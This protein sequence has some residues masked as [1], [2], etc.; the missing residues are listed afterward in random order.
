MHLV[1]TP[2]VFPVGELPTIRTLR[3]YP[4]VVDEWYGIR[5]EVTWERPFDSA[6][7][8]RIRNRQQRE[9]SEAHPACVLVGDWPVDYQVSKH[10]ISQVLS[11]PAYREFWQT[12][13]HVCCQEYEDGPTRE[14]VIPQFSSR[15]FQ[16][17]AWR[18]DGGDLGASRR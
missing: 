7:L 4:E 5:V 8:D 12:E 14:V 13:H 15:E 3:V 17:S 1:E 11:H 6:L 2:A 18:R 16:H 10:V 9:F